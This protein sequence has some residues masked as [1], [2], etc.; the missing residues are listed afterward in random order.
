MSMRKQ[1]EL[2]DPSSCLIEAKGGEML[3][4]LPGRDVAAPATIRAWI[5]ERIRL[6]KNEPG[7]TQLIEAEECARVMEAGR[8]APTARGPL[9][10]DDID[11][12]IEQMD[13]IARDTDSFEYGLPSFGRPREMLRIAVREWLAPL[14][15]AP[16]EP[17]LSSEAIE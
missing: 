13:R 9:A 10:D 1:S 6:G 5:A 12:L 4:V 17:T 7:D 16:K 3:F 8:A 2:M 14:G 15:L 11:D